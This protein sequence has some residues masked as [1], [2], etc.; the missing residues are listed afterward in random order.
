MVRVAS[1]FLVLLKVKNEG[2]DDKICGP[3]KKENRS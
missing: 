1:R 3:N 2:K